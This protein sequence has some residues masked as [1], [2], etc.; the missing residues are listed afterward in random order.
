MKAGEV[1]AIVRNNV[2]R[3]A[4]LTTDE[5]R[6]YWRFGKAFAGHD[7]VLHA[8]L[9]NVRGDIHTNTVEDF[10]SIF[11]RGIRGVSQHCGEQ[12]LNRYLVVFDF[13]YTHRSARGVEVTQ[14]P[15]LPP[16]G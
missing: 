1:S 16:E 7:R 2:A 5:S 12:Q 6:F 13:R 3:E 8:V 10:F 4:K 11:N 14:S 9:E 15:D